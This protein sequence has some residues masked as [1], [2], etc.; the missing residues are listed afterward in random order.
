[1]ES[2]VAVPFV[3]RQRVY[4][5]MLDLLGVLHNAAYI[6]LF[7][8]ARTDFWRSLGIAGYGG[9]GM[10]WPYLVARNEVNYRAAIRAEQE[11]AVYVWVAALGT[12]SLTFGHEVHAEDGAL[13]ADGRTVLVRIDVETRRPT[14]WSSRFRALLEPHIRADQP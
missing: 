11:V 10:D 6:L 14:P 12:S 5:D 13:V 4:W 7:E 3:S 1:M 8:R 9:E 2:G